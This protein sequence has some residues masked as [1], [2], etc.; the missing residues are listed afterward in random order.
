MKLGPSRIDCLDQPPASIVQR[1]S[2]TA[3][4]NSRSI[5]RPRRIPGVARRH[6]QAIGAG[7]NRHDHA[8]SRPH[9]GEH[10][11]ETHRRRHPVNVRPHHRDGNGWLGRCSR[12]SLTCVAGSEELFEAQC[13]DGSLSE[14][15]LSLRWLG[16]SDSDPHLDVVL[17]HAAMD[18]V[19]RGVRRAVE[20]ELGGYRQVE[21]KRRVR[22]RVANEE[23]RNGDSVAGD[24]QRPANGTSTIVPTRCEP[25][26]RAG[27][28][29][30]AGRKM[31][32]GN[33]DV[34]HRRLARWLRKHPPPIRRGA[35][36]RSLR[37]AC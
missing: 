25:G 34:R 21:S 2:D 35:T 19:L 37:P 16:T 14:S 26:T 8:N 24:R 29:S 33:C 23:D 12:I 15:Q 27:E 13:R 7:R 9:D 28:L 30:P 31:R 3:E 10:G 11:S 1:R 6:H 17:A 32:K 36:P 4:R 20:R 22:R 18:T 5:R